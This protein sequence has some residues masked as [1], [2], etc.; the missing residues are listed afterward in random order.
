MTEEE[1]KLFDALSTMWSGAWKQFN[2]RRNYE[3]KLSLG[4]WTAC[5]SFIGL[6]I[7][8]R[9]S[10]HLEG[11]PIAA[12]LAFLGLLLVLVHCYFLCGLDHACHNDMDIAKHY[13]L[14]MQSLSQSP[15]P[16]KLEDRLKEAR[17]RTGLKNWSIV[18]QAA[19]TLILLLL[20]YLAVLMTGRV[21]NTQSQL[22]PPDNNRKHTVIIR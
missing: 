5:A 8:G 4:V 20:C 13:E 15:F 11:W 3:W 19:I 16:D 14:K 18:S 21:Q 1:K 6:V 2:E 17:G 7:T 12:A 9:I 10:P 22:E